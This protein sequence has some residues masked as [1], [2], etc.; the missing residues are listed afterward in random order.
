MKTY[1]VRARV[2]NNV[3]QQYEETV[4]QHVGR[5]YTAENGQLKIWGQLVKQVVAE[6]SPGNWINIIEAPDA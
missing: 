3:T 1:Q 5:M 6:Y 2:W 4:Y